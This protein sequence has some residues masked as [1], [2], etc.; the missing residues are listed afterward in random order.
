M[1][2]AAFYKYDRLLGRKPLGNELTFAAL[3]VNP[4]IDHQTP[5][6]PLRL[7]PSGIEPAR[8]GFFADDA[9]GAS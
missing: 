4:A 8:A 6:V 1:S 7:N 9:I 2:N 5:P 3:S